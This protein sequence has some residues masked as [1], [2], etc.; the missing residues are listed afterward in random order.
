MPAKAASRLSANVATMP[1]ALDHYIR[2][3]RRPL[4]SLAFVMPLLLLYEGGVVMLGPQAVRNG[5]DVWLRQF[6]DALGFSQY[7]LLPALTVGLL[8]RLA[9]RHARSLAG[10]GRRGLRH[11]ARIGRAGTGAGGLAR[12]EGMLVASA[13]SGSGMTA[14]G[15]A[16][17]TATA[18]P[19]EMAG[20]GA[21]LGRLLGYVGA[22][23]YEE[24]LFRLMLI[25]PLAIGV[26]HFGVPRPGAWPAWCS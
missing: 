11:V 12:I 16:V 4:A 14:G 26:K 6:L 17:A 19:F 20:R 13:L 23:V 22:G 24:M 9:S 18:M 25:P 3:S 2:E 1:T 8:A 21:F 10:F 5:A 7:F 15:A